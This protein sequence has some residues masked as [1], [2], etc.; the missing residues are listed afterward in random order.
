M[1][2]ENALLIW[3]AR[4]IH[5]IKWDTIINHPDYGI[6]ISKTTITEYWNK[7]GIKPK[8]TRKGHDQPQKLSDEEIQRRLTCLIV[9]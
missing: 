5:K 4:Y 2:K 6:K 9:Y 1:N 7:Y 8:F 3:K